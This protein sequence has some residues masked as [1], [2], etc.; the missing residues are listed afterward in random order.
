MATARAELPVQFD[1]I[2]SF[3]VTPDRNFC[4]VAHGTIITLLNLET[5]KILL[6]FDTSENHGAFRSHA[7]YVAL[8]AD[9]RRLLTGYLGNERILGSHEKTA[10]LWDGI[11]GVLLCSFDTPDQLTS[12][13][14]SHDGKK[15]ICCYGNDGSMQ[16][17]DT[18]SQKLL[19]TH[20]FT[21]PNISGIHY[22]PPVVLWTARFSPDGMDLLAV[23]N[24]GLFM[25]DA[26]NGKIVKQFM[27]TLPTGGSSAVAWSDDGKKLIAIG[28]GEAQLWDAS[29]TNAVLTFKIPDGNITYVDFSPDD[30]KFVTSD[31]N[32]D[33]WIWDAATSNALFK[34]KKHGV[35]AIA[36][37]GDGNKILVAG[38]NGL[39]L[40]NANNG[41]FV[42]S[43]S[44]KN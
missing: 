16:C 30:A 5:E 28:T 3:A 4:L 41:A 18:V 6:N 20:I 17:W 44:L 1:S 7:E 14:I 42:K 25:L 15:A 39:E 37:V 2:H 40:W 11:T 43:I 34:L 35:K 19:W 21:D 23:L 12:L 8:S 38:E 13:A 24:T 33:V 10:R 32:G 22:S 31:L 27:P 9:H 26:S 36:L 29:I